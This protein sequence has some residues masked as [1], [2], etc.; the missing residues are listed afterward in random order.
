MPQRPSS[1]LRSAFI[2]LAGACALSTA[3]AQ[4]AAKPAQ[5]SVERGRYL[6]KIAGCNDCHTPGYAQ[7]GGKVPEAQWLVGDKLGFQGPWGTTYPANLRLLMQRMSQAE[8][9]KYAKTHEMRPPMPWFAL[10]DMTDQDLASIHR[11]VRHL[12]PAGDPAPEYL[13]PGKAPQGPV[14]KFPE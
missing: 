2:A 5:G 3:F 8:W 6:A 1:F 13:P 7:A 9:I 11:F 14:I 4:Q 12:G 10:R